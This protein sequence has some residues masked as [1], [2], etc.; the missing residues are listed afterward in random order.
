MLIVQF[1]NSVKYLLTFS[2]YKIE[3]NDLNYSPFMLR[4]FGFMDFSC[5]IEG[6]TFYILFIFIILW[7]FVWTYDI[8]YSVKHPWANTQNYA[9]Y[10][11]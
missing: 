1:V 8:Y 7:N 10:Y 9:F 6:L 5:K 11:K 2:V 4:D 3:G